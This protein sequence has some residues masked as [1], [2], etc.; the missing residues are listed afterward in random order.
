M[1]SAER[2]VLRIV[3]GD[4]SPEELAAVTA[5]ISAAG[6]SEAAA[7]PEPG[8]GRWNDPA[9]LVRRGWRAGPG[10]WLAAR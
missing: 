6:E 10:G 1:T 4:P 7:A 2:P 3:R 9:H 8:R 5:L